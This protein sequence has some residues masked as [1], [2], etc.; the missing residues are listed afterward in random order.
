MSPL[1][2]LPRGDNLAEVDDVLGKQK[3][4]AYINSS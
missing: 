2:G 4:L 1:P 3:W